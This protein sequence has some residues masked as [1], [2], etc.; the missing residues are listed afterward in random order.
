VR[1]A[2]LEASD[3]SVVIKGE[4]PPLYRRDL[5]RAV[6]L[7]SNELEMRNLIVCHVCGNLIFFYVWCRGVHCLLRGFGIIPGLY[8]PQPVN[9][10]PFRTLL[11]PY[12]YLHFDDMSWYV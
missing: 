4:Q 2:Y 12:F 8:H 10:R 7:E 9:Y 3:L 1:F 11:L 5:Y 6:Y